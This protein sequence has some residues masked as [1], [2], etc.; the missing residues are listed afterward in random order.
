VGK[1]AIVFQIEIYA[2]LQCAYKNI[3]RA[4]RNK[5]MLIFSDSQVALRAL[6][7]PKVMSDLVAECLNAL[8]G[9]EGRNEVILAWVPGH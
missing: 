6:V 5:R 4:Y 3:R 7:G 1:F 9:L 2:I 8:S